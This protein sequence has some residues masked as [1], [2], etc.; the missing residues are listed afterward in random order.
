MVVFLL[1]AALALPPVF[2]VSEVQR[3]QQGECLTVF[4]GD[5]IE[6]FAFEVKGVMRNY[7]G[8]NRDVVLI[9]LLGAKPEFTGVV[10]GMSGSPCSIGGRL[11]GALA[12]SFATFAKEP[13][14]GI[15]P[16]EG[17]RDVLRLPE[18][19]RPWRLEQEEHMPLHARVD[20][21]EATLRPIAAPLAMSGVTSEVLEEYTPWLREVGFEP[22][23]GG[24][25]GSSKTAARPLAPGSA[26]AAVLVR[27]DVEV[28]A[29]GTVTWVNGDE[30]LAFGHPFFGGGA[31]SIPMAQASIVNTMVSSM[32]SFKMSITGPTL[33]EITQDRLT[34]IGGRMGRQ[35]SMIPV[36]GVMRTPGGVSKYRF[37]V[38]RDLQL[39]S[40]FVS[41]GLANAISGRVDASDRGVV[42]LNGDIRIAGQKPVHL[43]DVFAANRDN[44]LLQSSAAEMGQ[45]LDMLWRSPFGSAPAVEIDVETTVEP[46]PVIESIEAIYLDRSVAHVGDTV[47]VVARLRRE[48]SP[49]IGA[50]HNEQFSVRIPRH[51]AGRTVTL[52]ACGAA[53]AEQLLYESEGQPHFQDMSDIVT[54]LNMRRS[55]GGLYLLATRDGV[56]M[57]VG[58]QLLPFLPPSVVALQSGDTRT[59]RRGFAVAWEDHKTRPGVVYGGVKTNLTIDPL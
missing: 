27:G 55:S 41:M 18:E 25:M 37:E 23:A 47:N 20:N 38:A 6:P 21:A 17:M 42:R 4:E 51:W 11:L 12:Y 57:R 32:R 22:V 28:A 59:E 34:A 35:P 48:G 54:W 15:T 58:V 5:L 40:K 8:P 14:A 50:L 10:A 29:T 45:A 9:K 2:P 52:H 24:S 44:R 26:V 46:E 7:L 33:G 13:I 19:K 3:G 36:R 49:G 39:S 31:V 30:V 16:I 1:A 56:G 53:E 43:S